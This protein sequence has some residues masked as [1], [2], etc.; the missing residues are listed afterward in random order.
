MLNSKRGISPLIASVILVTFVLFVGVIVVFWGRNFITEKAEKEGV[1]AEKQLKCENINLEI[2]SIDNSNK[3]IVL[4][5]TGNE[6][7]DGF[8][9]KVT[10]GGSGAEKI[11]QKVEPLKT[12][13]IT[14]SF[15][16]GNNAKID[17]IPSL[18][19]EGNN[20]PI[21]PCSNKHKL[22]KVE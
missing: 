12:V 5:N 15:N 8:I 19:P 22:I 17:L 14:Y 10:S 1:L 7:I 2:K 20:A 18:K 3:N 16:L 9:L 11:I 21:V 4:T 13:T 6:I